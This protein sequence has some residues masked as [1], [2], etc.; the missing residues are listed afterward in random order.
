M[1][2]KLDDIEKKEAFKVPDGYFEELPL[3]IQQRVSN[4]KKTYGFNVPSW[5][6]A[7]AASLLLVVTFVFVLPGNE[8]SAEE[9]L[10]EISQE[11][12]VA[13]LD[14]IELDEYDIASAIGDDVNDLE[15]ENT[16][17]LDAIDLEDQSI[18]DVLLEYDLGDEYL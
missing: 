16:N 10:A 9:L 6:L 2:Y 15:F 4:E 7:L 1:K 17:I 14:Q 8:Q 3:K 11:E 5:S 13:Y 18:D 12:I